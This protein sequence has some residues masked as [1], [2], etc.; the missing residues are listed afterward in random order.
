MSGDS[1]SIPARLGGPRAVTLDAKEANRWPIL[2]EED[3]AAVLAVLRDG[4]LSLHPVTRQLEEDYRAHLGVR[5]ALAHCN[6]TAAL[7]AAFYA[8]DLNPGDEILVPSATHWASVVPMLWVG[9]LPVFCESEPDRLGIDPADIEG[10]ITSRS[11]AIVVTHLW[12]LPCKMDEIYELAKRHDLKIIEDASHAQGATWRGRPCGSLGDVSVISLQTSKLA[13]AGEGGIFLTNHDAF[14]ERAT[15]MGSLERTLE[16]QSTSRRFAGTTFGVKTRLSPMSSAI[17]RV[18][19]KHLPE[20]NAKR[21]ANLRYLS[22]RLEPLGFNTYL[23][24]AEVERVYFKFLIHYDQ[25]R[26]GLPVELLAESLRAEGCE[27][28]APKNR[29][30]LLHQ[31]PLFTES[32]FAQFPAFK[33]RSDLILPV[34][35][36]DALPRT[37]AMSRDLLTLPVFPSASQDLLDQ[38]IVAFQKVLAHTEEIGQS[39][40]SKSAAN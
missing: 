14:M 10:K 36:P 27:V 29:Y 35:K 20:R 21:N 5:H 2:T 30:P 7:L 6:G 28:V 31:Q 24:P 26:W 13:P 22:E 12:G 9:A 1:E 17:A 4:D 32:R 38:H 39:A 19:L 34:Y 40:K 18:Q 11:R 37:E 16:L 33:N 23:G 3:E 15:C 8:L 25:Q